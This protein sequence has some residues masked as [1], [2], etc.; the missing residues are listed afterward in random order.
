MAGKSVVTHDSTQE[1]EIQPEDLTHEE[2]AARSYQCWQERGDAP[3]SAEADWQ[4]AEQELRAER[5][6][7]GK[8][9]QSAA[10]SG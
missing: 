3:G 9:V 4:Q 10:A 2:I 7:T 8:K 1:S 6:R 5:A